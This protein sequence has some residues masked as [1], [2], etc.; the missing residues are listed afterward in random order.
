MAGET[1][2]LG[3]LTDLRCR[4]TQIER[5]GLSRRYFAGQARRAML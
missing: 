5:S 3:R 1:L 4:M 2:T